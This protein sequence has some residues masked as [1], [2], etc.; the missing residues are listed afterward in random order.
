MELRKRFISALCFSPPYV[1]HN[2]F[3]VSS[4]KN[5][6]CTTIINSL[7]DVG[8]IFIQIIFFLIFLVHWL[9]NLYYASVKHLL[10]SL[11]DQE[12]SWTFCISFFMVYFCDIFMK[13]EF[14]NKFIDEIHW[15]TFVFRSDN[16]SN[17]IKFIDEIRWKTFVF[18]SDI[19]S[20][21]KFFFWI[22]IWTYFKACL[23]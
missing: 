5:S 2:S 13:S 12:S 18:P 23:M 16:I 20:G 17:G 22:F 19:A 14:I 7:F 9:L 21:I 3:S 6:I 1:F 15:K 8:F 4:I 10:T 11:T